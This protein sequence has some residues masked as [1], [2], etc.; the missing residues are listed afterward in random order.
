[1]VIV[2]SA[3]TK[4][5]V[6]VPTLP[7]RYKNVATT[8]GIDVSEFQGTVNWKKVKASGVNCVIIRVGGRGYG[9]G[10]IYADVKFDTNM[11]GAIAAGLQVGVYFYTQAVSTKEAIAE[12]DYCV[13]KAKKYNVTL[14]IYMDIEGVDYDEGRLDKKNY[15]K[16]QMTNLVKAFCNRIASYN[17]T[18]GVYANKYWLEDK[19]NGAGLAKLYSVWLAHFNST[20]GYNG[21][22][23]AWQYSSVGKVPGISGTVDLDKFFLNAPRTPTNL[24]VV[25]NETIYQAKAT[26]TRSAEAYKYQLVR[27]D[28]ANKKWISV[29]TTTKNSMILTNLSQN[30]TYKYKIRAYKYL[31]GKNYYSSY[32]PVFTYKTRADRVK[33]LKVSAYSASTA[34]V[35]W[36]KLNGATGYIVYK[37]N[38]STKKYDRLKTLTNVKSTNYRVTG[39]KSTSNYQI[40]VKAYTKETNGK[41]VYHNNSYVRVY[42]APTMVKNF[43]AKSK[44]DST[45]TLTWDMTKGSSG[46]QILVYNE[47]L[48]KYTVAKTIGN[49]K[50]EE[51]TFKNLIDNKQYKFKIRAYKTVNGKRYLGARTTTD[52][53]VKTKKKVAISNEAVLTTTTTTKTTTITNKTTTTTKKATTTTTKKK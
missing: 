37:Y 1:M 51:Y 18:P 31:N 24:K 9:S 40:V 2:G 33:N 17:Y 42:T 29:G 41:T 44:T 21:E 25:E 22:F 47:K 13:K 5:S 7:T 4:F 45:I 38:T 19:I 14:P 35:T 53:V 20:T 26:W 8:Y 39:L 12:A 30:T 23:S 48:K 50:L 43:K 52:V 11:K 32:S 34:I 28:E 6:T 27:Y 3:A 46:Y 36:D 10:D 49:Y 15:N 16:T